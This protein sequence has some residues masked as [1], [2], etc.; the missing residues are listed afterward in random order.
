MCINFMMTPLFDNAKSSRNIL[1]YFPPNIWSVIY[2]SFGKNISS[3]NNATANIIYFVIKFWLR[4]FE[5]LMLF[6]SMNI[7]FLNHKAR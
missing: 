3:S 2:V 1:Y 4:V 7:H 5:N 6:P